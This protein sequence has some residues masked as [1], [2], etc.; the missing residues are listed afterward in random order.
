MTKFK[1]TLKEEKM[2]NL[3][4]T[5]AIGLIVFGIA[6]CSKKGGGGGGETAPKAG[7][8]G[9]AS[10][11]VI[12]GGAAEGPVTWS[13]SANNIYYGEFQRQSDGKTCYYGLVNNADDTTLQSAVSDLQTILNASNVE[14]GT[15]EDFAFNSA[16]MP[17]I[18]IENS[19]GS[20]TY[21]L[22]AK[23]D[24]PASAKTLSNAN[25]VLEYYNEVLNELISRYYLYCPGK[26]DTSQN[27]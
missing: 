9:G 22:V 4:R 12:N 6:N 23:E 5:L 19:S 7:L 14:S 10:Q 16:T 21:Y 3:L 13:S 18:T 11:I 1:K 27:D 8:A 25:E 17:T 2:K 24:I 26:K 20:E 15:G